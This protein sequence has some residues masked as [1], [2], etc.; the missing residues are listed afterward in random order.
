[1]EAAA[2]DSPIT[3]LEAPF[4]VVYFMNGWEYEDIWVTRKYI[5]SN[6]DR[7][8]N[9]TLFHPCGIRLFLFLQ[10][11]PSSLDIHRLPA[12]HFQA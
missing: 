3:E 2:L 5:R 10:P 9:F 4:N 6:K 7:F 11:K 8:Q 1:M 12:F